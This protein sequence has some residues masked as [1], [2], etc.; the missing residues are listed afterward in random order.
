MEELHTMSE[1][2][3]LSNIDKNRYQYHESIGAYDIYVDKT[4]GEFHPVPINLGDY[5]FVNKN[6][7]DYLKNRYDLE[8]NRLKDK[9]GSFFR[10][11]TELNQKLV[12]SLTDRAFVIFLSLYVDYE[13]PLNIDGNPL[14]NEDIAKLWQVY[15]KDGIKEVISLTKTRERLSRLVEK[16]ILIRLK[17][18]EDGRKSN[19]IFNENYLFQG[20]SSSSDGEIEKFVK[21]YQ[22]KLNDVIK[23]IKDRERK[24]NQNRRNDKKIDIVS[25]IGLL[26][27]IIPYV[28]KQ[29]GYLVK[30]PEA[31]LKI[32]DGESVFLAIRRNPKLLKK[33]P[34]SWISKNLGYKEMNRNTLDNYFQYLADAGALKIDDTYGVKMYLMHPHLM[35][36]KDSNAKTHLKDLEGMFGLHEG[37]NEFEY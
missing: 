10:V 36:K 26:H 34:K 24:R 29:S 21:L 7:R 6:S 4:T 31:E 14:R 1:E 13:R 30:N 12:L 5:E 19:Y 11:P 37:Q 2:T 16:D 25:V 35:Y 17:D 32:R 28:H 22:R 27:S 8:Q 20:S 9:R 18:E 15:N 3:L 33:L 23:R